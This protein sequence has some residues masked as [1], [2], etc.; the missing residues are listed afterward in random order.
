MAKYFNDSEDTVTNKTYATCNFMPEILTD[1]KTAEHVNSS[2]LK[3]R[4]EF[5]VAH[6]WAKDY[7]KHNEHNVE[8][9]NIKLYICFKK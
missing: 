9:I 1:D 3:Q 5:N 2:N 4:E 6:T 8:L 7:V